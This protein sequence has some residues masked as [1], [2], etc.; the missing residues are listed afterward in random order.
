MIQLSPITT[1]SSIYTNG[2]ILQ[3]LP[4]FAFGEISALGLI[5]LAIIVNCQFS[6]IHYQLLPATTEGRVQRYHR[7]HLREVVVDLLQFSIE[8]LRLGG[9]HL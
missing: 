5:S 2:N 3:L 8:Q 6:I 7:L 9:E 4:I 1:S